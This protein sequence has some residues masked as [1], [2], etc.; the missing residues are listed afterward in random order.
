MTRKLFIITVLLLSNCSVISYSE[1]FPLAKIA[2][3]GAEDIEIN[4]EYLDSKQ[5]SFAK[6]KVGRSAIA[7]FSLVDISENGVYEWISG[8][9]EILNTFNGKIIN[10]SNSLYEVEFLQYKEFNDIKVEE[11]ELHYDL[12]LNNPMAFVSQR[13]SIRVEN[14]SKGSVITENIETV[15]FKWTYTNSYTMN[16]IGR[17]INTTQSIH[18]KLPEIQIFFYYK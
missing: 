6:V 15:G 5:F 12:F 14:V 10:L 2:I 16:N 8:D 11:L 7:I 3:L 4:Q 17:V 13:A 9:G 1:V 18:P